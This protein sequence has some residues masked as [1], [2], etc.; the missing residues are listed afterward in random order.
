MYA[1]VRASM[2]ACLPARIGMRTGSCGNV[3]D[4]YSRSTKFKYR[5]GFQLLYR[6]FPQSVRANVKMV[7]SNTIK[8]IV[9]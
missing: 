4:V 8:K 5:Q 6:D 3:P 2:R 9:T 7:S 1:S